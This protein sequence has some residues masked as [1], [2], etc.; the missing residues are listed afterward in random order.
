MCARIGNKALT[1]YKMMRILPLLLALASGLLAALS[2]PPWNVSWIAFVALIPFLT[3]TVV[4]KAGLL[5][6]IASGFLFGGSFGAAT[7]GWLCAGG[8]WP[9]WLGNVG[10]LAGI[11]I[12]WSWFLWRF[13]ELPPLGQTGGVER[14][15]L[16]PILP[17][18]VGQ[19]AAWKASLDHLRIACLVAS[20]WTFLEWGRSVLMPGW[21]F[22]GI[23]LADNLALLQVTRFTGASGLTF[24]A[25]FANVIALTTVRRLVREPGRMTWAS[26][27]DFM[28]TLG[29]IFLIALGGF[30]SLQKSVLLDQRQIGSVLSQTDD[31]D[32]LIDL[33]KDALTSD[34]VVWNRAE[35]R[36]SDYAKLSAASFGRTLG[37]VTGVA[38][39]PGRAISGCL[40]FI[41]EAIKKVLIPRARGAIF[42]PYLAQAAQ[43]LDPFSYKGASWL[44]LLNWEA[45]S[46]L[47]LRGAIQS[48]AQVL[49]VLLDPAPPSRIGAAQLF[50][51]LRVWST[52]F[53]RPLIFS[54]RAGGAAIVNSVG[55]IVASAD[56]AGAGE[57]IRGRI[58]IPPAT[59]LTPYLQYSDWLPIVCGMLC[60]MLGITERL[61]GTYAKPGRL[62]T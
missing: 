30:A 57:L 43:H 10:S 53:G 21:N 39:A 1:A 41:P 61:Y 50:K 49:I 47:L 26:R 46:P 31:V 9:D 8:R 29:G 42:R 4:R 44:P 51:N 5:T 25:V 48:Q 52:G 19:S 56:H 22:L 60:I 12:T 37:L 20:C 23:P 40:V 59:A 16:G 2:F 7:F 6:A 32:R 27:F 3:G 28:M 24:I 45:G 13:V 34:L 54:S 14:K 62:A 18:S 55:R 36:Q 15:R 58:D 38:S 17:G 11:G 33:S 35:L